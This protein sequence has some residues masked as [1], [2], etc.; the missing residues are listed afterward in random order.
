MTADLD[1]GNFEAWPWFAALALALMAG[2][3]AWFHRSRAAS[4]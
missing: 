3:W 4:R 1:A 2:E